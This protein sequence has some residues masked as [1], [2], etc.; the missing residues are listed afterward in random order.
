MCVSLLF[1]TR[2]NRQ[3]YLS[4]KLCLDTQKRSGLGTKCCILSINH[5]CWHFLHYLS[6]LPSSLALAWSANSS[7]CLK[8]SF[9]SVYALHTCRNEMSHGGPDKLPQDYT[10]QC[11]AMQPIPPII[12]N[13]ST[14][15]LQHQLPF[16]CLL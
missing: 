13:G 7:L 15:H 9:N 14:R 6:H 1:L 16:L 8:G 5:L 3:F 11:G 10:Q 12:C 4:S 2:T